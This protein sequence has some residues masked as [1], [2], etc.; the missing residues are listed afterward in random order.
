MFTTRKEFGGSYHAERGLGA[1]G[2]PRWGSWHRLYFLFKLRAEIAPSV[3]YQYFYVLP[4]SLFD[5]RAALHVDGPKE[6]GYIK[7]N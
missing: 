5:E 1:L 7:A 4:L 2:D 3:R 6:S